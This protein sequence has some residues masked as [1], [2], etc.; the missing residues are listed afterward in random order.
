MNDAR[1]WT[2]IRLFLDILSCLLLGAGLAGTSWADGPESDQNSS[3]TL[4][5]LSLEQ[6]GDVEVTTASKEPEQVWRTPAAVYVLTQEDIRRSGATS[7]PEVLRLVPG[8]EVARVNSSVWAVGIRGFGSGFSKSVLVLI[9]GRSVYTPLF[10]GVEWNL[11]NLLL[12]DVDRIEVIR[13][14]GGTIWGSN[15]VNGVINIITKSAKETHGELATAGAGNS[16]RGAGAIRYGGGHGDGFDYRAYAIGFGRSPGYHV[17]GD[18]YDDWQLGQAGFRADS[19]PTARDRLTVQGDLYKGHIGQQIGIA[20]LSPPAQLNV[21]GTQYVSGGNLLARWRRELSGGSD[22]QVQAYYDRT[23]RLGP[24]LGETRNTFDFDAIHHFVLQRNEIVW[25]LGARWSPSDLIQTVATVNFLPHHEAD[26][27]YSLF[28]QDQIAIVQNKLWL[29]VGSKFEHNIFT[30]WENQPSGRVLWT[31][32]PHQTFWGAVS[33]AVRTPSRVDEDLQLTGFVSNAPPA[34]LYVC[35]CDNGK[36]VSETLLS[37]E[38]GYR[39]LV[40]SRLYLVVAAFHN[41]YNDLESYGNATVSIVSSPPPGYTLLSLPFANGIMGSTNGGE[42]APDWKAARWMELKA[43]YSYLSMDLLDKP[44]HTKTSYVSTYE[45]SSPHHEATAQAI[46]TLPKRFEFDPAYRYVAALP[47]QGVKSY[48]TA[49]AWLGWNLASRL[50]LSVTGQNLL[51]PHHAEFGGDPTGLV[52]VKRSV[53]GQV[54]WR[55]AD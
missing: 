36:F 16:D 17:N 48:S 43:S 35:V 54:T 1:Y 22:F 14:P 6:L 31:P 49:D 10:A 9:D 11:Q 2:A 40:N 27:L 37:Y 53:Y 45:G 44:T 32:T 46:L 25:G 15:A 3:V 23:Y 42:I 21:D 26:N 38:A 39:K 55:G 18:N 52:G 13:G 7:I 28:A 20:Y 51:Q 4:K 5:H 24:Q 30:G 47:A 50:E 41:K 8:V 19:S 29:T 12:A 33:R 34:P